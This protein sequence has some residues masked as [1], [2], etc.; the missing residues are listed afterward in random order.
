MADLARIPLRFSA[1]TKRKGQDYVLSGAVERIAST[2]WKVQGSREQPY[3]VNAD[4]EVD[5]GGGASWDWATCS[6]PH[7]RRNMDP[8]CSHLFAALLHVLLAD[9]GRLPD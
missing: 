8:S 7:G 9:R 2:A 3:V 1:E 4:I 6:C 5:D